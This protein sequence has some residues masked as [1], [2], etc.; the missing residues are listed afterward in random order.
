ME[1]GEEKQAQQARAGV[2]SGCGT[3]AEACG[4]ARSNSALRTPAYCQQQPESI[5][6]LTIAKNQA[7]ARQGPCLPKCGF[8]V[9]K[10]DSFQSRAEMEAW[11]GGTVLPAAARDDGSKLNVLVMMAEGAPERS[12]ADIAP[13]KAAARAHP[14]IFTFV[15]TAGAL[16]SYE[17]FPVQ[18][19]QHIRQW[20]DSVSG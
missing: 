14:D 18:A 15:E 8:L 19:A 11:L 2:A 17:E 7:F 16:R 5:N 12:T 4:F 20:Q 13:L 3:A 9:G 6:D 10:A 1:R